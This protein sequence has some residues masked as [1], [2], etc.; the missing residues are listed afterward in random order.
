MPKSALLIVI[1]GFAAASD[2]REREI[3]L[4]TIFS[5]FSAVHE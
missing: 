4:R 3:C 2:T 5:A 1:E